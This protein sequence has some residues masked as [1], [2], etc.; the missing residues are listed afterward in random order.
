MSVVFP[1]SFASKCPREQPVPPGKGGHP[2][3]ERIAVILI[4]I[5]DEIKHVLPSLSDLLIFIFSFY[6]HV[7]TNPV[8]ELP[9]MR[10]TLVPQEHGVS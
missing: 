8:S 10:P 4:D 6:S 5:C 9:S 2:G 7:E 1:E 3:Q